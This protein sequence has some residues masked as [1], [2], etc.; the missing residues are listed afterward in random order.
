MPVNLKVHLIGIQL[1]INCNSYSYAPSFNC[2]P[3][4]GFINFCPGLFAS[5]SDS[6]NIEVAL[7]ELTHALV[8]VM[9]ALLLCYNPFLFYIFHV[10][11]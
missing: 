5:L 2:R 1:I 4:S 9:I 10:G 11:I 3:I 8:S 6:D 7:H